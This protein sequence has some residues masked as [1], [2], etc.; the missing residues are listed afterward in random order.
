MNTLINEKTTYF[1]CLFFSFVLIKNLE[2]IHFVSLKEN[3][4]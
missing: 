1:L 3:E 2:K 4:K